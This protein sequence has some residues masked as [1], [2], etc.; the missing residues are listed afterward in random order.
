MTTIT[1]ES[2]IDAIDQVLEDCDDEATF[3]RKT[4]ELIDLGDTLEP[5][6]CDRF[7]ALLEQYVAQ[8]QHEVDARRQMTDDELPRRDETQP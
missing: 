6:E 8:L 7:Y 2:I 3:E 1:A 5:A 4:D